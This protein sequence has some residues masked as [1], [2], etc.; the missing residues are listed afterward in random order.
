MSEKKT[1]KTAEVQSLNYKKPYFAKQET[2]NFPEKIWEKA[3]GGKYHQTC[4]RCH[5]CR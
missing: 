4:S 5:H 1:S 3:N 2:M